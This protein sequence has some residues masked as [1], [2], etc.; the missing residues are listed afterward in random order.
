MNDE[1]EKLPE[2]I[3]IAD[4]LIYPEILTKRER[5]PIKIHEEEKSLFHPEM[6][7]R[8]QLRTISEE[9]Y[10]SRSSIIDHNRV[11]LQ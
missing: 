11:T 5:S 1:L 8:R 3:K 2:L 9:I 7:D 6:I 4:D 10:K